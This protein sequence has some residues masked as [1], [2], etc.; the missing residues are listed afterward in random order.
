MEESDYETSD[1][2]A[3]LERARPVPHPAFR[4]ELRR[5]LLAREEDTARPPALR[6]LIA[7][8]AASGALLLLVGAAGLAGLGPLAA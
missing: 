3:R 2:E 7:G 8:Y 4:G 1:L 6:R 5:S